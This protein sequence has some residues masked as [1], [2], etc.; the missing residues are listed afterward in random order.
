LLLNLHCSL[1][2]LVKRSLTLQGF[3]FLTLTSGY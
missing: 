3:A 1:I 2:V